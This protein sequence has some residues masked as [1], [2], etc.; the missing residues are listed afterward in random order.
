VLVATGND[1]RAVEAAANA[2]AARDGRYSS[3]SGANITGGM[4]SVELEM[5]LAVGTVGGLTANHPQANKAFEILGKPSATELMCIV[6]ATGL[7]NNFAA[8][9]ALVSTGIQSGHM[10]MHLDNILDRFHASKEEK[11]VAREHFKDKTISFSK[12]ETF[13]NV[14]RK[15]SK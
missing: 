8:V 1:Y 13:I 11:M 7:A 12:V 15:T 14:W 4:F 10:R 2:Y 5:P 9:K 6:A 3:L